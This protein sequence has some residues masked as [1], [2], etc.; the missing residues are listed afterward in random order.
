MKEKNK[1]MSYKVFMITLLIITII[2][3]ALTLYRRYKPNNVTSFQAPGL[4]ISQDYLV[5]NK[6]SRSE[7]PLKHVSGIVVH[8]TANPGS[9]AKNNRNYFNNLRKT[10][11]TYASSHFIVG[12]KGEIIQC[13]PLNEIAYAS[14]QRNK[15][16][17][18]I[19]TCHPDS[20]GKFNKQTYASLQKLV[21]A[22]MREY[23]LSRKDVIRHYDVTGKICP[24]YFVDH[25]EEWE[26]FINS[27]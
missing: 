22:L 3:G 27:L 18:S 21:R 9:T 7:I 4:K 20:T 16:T 25:P 14:N 23:H 6:Y 5:P 24:K 11:T 2:L 19:E 12:L 26:R 15:D 1:K 8:Y 13:L 17:I 10:H